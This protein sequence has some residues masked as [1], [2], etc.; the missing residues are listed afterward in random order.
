M[1]EIV[2]GTRGIQAVG[3]WAGACVP[4]ADRCDFLKDKDKPTLVPIEAPIR[5]LA[6]GYDAV[7]KPTLSKFPRAT[8]PRQIP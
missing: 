6:S 4:A 8:A 3:K 7:N 5:H 2:V 1:Q